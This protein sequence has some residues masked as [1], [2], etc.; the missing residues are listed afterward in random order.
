MDAPPGGNPPRG[1]GGVPRPGPPRSTNL[2]SFP[3]PPREK[4]TSPSIPGIWQK[5]LE[6]IL[7]VPDKD[8]VIHA[9]PSLLHETK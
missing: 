5:S 8:I 4:K 3:A 1:E 7:Q 9:H 6:T 2:D